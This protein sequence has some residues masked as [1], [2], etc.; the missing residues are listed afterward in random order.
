MLDNRIN[1]MLIKKDKRTD[2]L[3]PNP[4][5][6]ETPMTIPDLEIPGNA[7]NDWKTAFQHRCHL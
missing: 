2:F 4:S 7:A 6:N 3:T 1:G 5:N